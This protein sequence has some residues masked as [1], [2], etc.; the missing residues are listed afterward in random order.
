M[1]VTST[2]IIIILVATILTLITILLIIWEAEHQ[3]Y[4]FAL[5]PSEST[6]TDMAG[7]TT[8][9]KGLEGSIKIT[10]ANV[11]RDVMFNIT[12]KNKLFCVWSQ[13]RHAIADCSTTAFN[14]PDTYR[15]EGAYGFIYEI[16]DDGSYDL[17]LTKVV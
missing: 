6:S 10:Y 14:L 3:M 11:T 9:A 16:S 15:M 13:A 5:R 17:T 2:D 1:G 4:I 12:L 7:L 8:L